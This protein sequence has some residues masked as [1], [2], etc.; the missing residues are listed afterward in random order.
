MRII[1]NLR[2][3]F[4]EPEQ[5]ILPFH[6]WPLPDGRGICETDNFAPV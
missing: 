1:F 4:Y 2:D 6:S 5:S 3:A